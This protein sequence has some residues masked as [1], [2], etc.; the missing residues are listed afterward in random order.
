MLKKL[1]VFYGM[2]VLICDGMVCMSLE[3]MLNISIYHKEDIDRVFE[4]HSQFSDRIENY[5]IRKTKPKK[6]F[7]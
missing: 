3:T 7:P 6:K 2:I 4:P 5:L 1:V